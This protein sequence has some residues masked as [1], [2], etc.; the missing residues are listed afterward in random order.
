M[1]ISYSDIDKLLII[2]DADDPMTYDKDFQ[3]LV[4][5]GGMIK[6]TPQF[7]DEN[8]EAVRE[9]KR[10]N[11]LDGKFILEAYSDK[12]DDVAYRLLPSA[13]THRALIFRCVNIIYEEGMEP[14]DS[15]EAGLTEHHF[16]YE[17]RTVS[18]GPKIVVLGEDDDEDTEDEEEP[19]DADNT[20]EAVTR[21]EV[22]A[23]DLKSSV[24]F[25]TTK[26]FH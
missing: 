9:N 3:G 16:I 8:R 12:L 24:F 20:S 5:Y 15:D 17:L 10:G 1:T 4:E 19:A 14:D 23:M 6:D 2:I 7:T 26:V 13:D 21:D 25:R 11:M 18:V 22:D